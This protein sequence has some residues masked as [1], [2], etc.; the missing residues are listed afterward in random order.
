MKINLKG[1]NINITD[2]I[3]YE[4]ERKYDR[5]DKY[6]SNEKEVNLLI[7]KEGNGYKTEV[8]ISGTRQVYFASM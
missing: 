6:F 4:A 3:R 2:D 7:S 1:K 5:L 8:T